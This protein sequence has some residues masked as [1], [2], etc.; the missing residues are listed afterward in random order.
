MSHRLKRIWLCQDVLKGKQ[1]EIFPWY[2]EVLHMRSGQ[3]YWN[4]FIN[5][6]CEM[7]ECLA[8]L[9]HF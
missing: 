7:L 2:A 4:M 5:A 6:L 1:S 3:E 9:V 8:R